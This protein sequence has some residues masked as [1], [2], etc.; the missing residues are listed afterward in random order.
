MADILPAANLLP[1]IMEGESTS[2]TFT[3]DLAATET[4]TSLRIISTD[5]P[6]NININ[7]ATFS[8]TFSNL[9][10]LE[11]GALKYRDGLGYGEVDSFAD[12]PPKGTVQL[13][14]YKAPRQMLKNFN[15][16]VQLIASDTVDPTIEI[17]ITKDY[18]QPIQGDWNIFR[19]Q[20]IN[21][22]R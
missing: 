13:Y 8:G 19:Q 2:F 5:F 3:P 7:G 4:L 20:F 10:K 9:F 1:V 18:I 6:P 17:N 14:S 12:L 22:V 21:Y 11:P 15:V 16:R